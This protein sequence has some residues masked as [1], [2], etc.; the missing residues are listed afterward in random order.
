MVILATVFEAT[1]TLLFTKGR[2]VTTTSRV[3]RVSVRFPDPHSAPGVWRSTWIGPGRGRVHTFLGRSIG[4]G[5]V[6]DGGNVRWTLSDIETDTFRWRKQAQQ[7]DGEWR[8]Q[9]T[10]RVWRQK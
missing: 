1:H 4:T 8:L 5:I 9:Q 2:N 7:P 6:L 10:F 3:T